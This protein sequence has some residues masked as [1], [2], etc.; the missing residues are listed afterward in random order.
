MLVFY[1]V[2]AIFLPYNDEVIV[3]KYPSLCSLPLMTQQLISLS[4][5]ATIEHPGHKTMKYYDTYA[6]DYLQ[7]FTSQNREKYE[8]E[9]RVGEKSRTP[10]PRR[11]PPP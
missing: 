2:S 6:R 8:R 1:D 11:Q 4:G 9:E 3:Q 5:E 10:S 7:R